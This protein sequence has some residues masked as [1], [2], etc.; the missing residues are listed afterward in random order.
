[1]IKRSTLVVFLVF[2]F[3]LA[4]C[5]SPSA[6]DAIPAA[7]PSQSMPLP[8]D[9]RDYRYCEVIPV[10]QD[11]LTL[12]VTVYNTL[13]LNDC[14]AD[15]WAK[16]DAD[17]ISEQYGASLVKLNGPRYWVLNKIIGK[18]ES[19]NGKVVNF[20]G[21]E[22]LQRATLQ[23]NLWQG[24]IG[25]KFYT[26]NTVKRET[27]FEYWAGNEVYELVSPAG[28]TYIMQSYAQM[29]DPNLTIADLASLGMRLKLPQG[30][31]FQAI[32]LDEDLRL[33]ANGAAYVINDDLYNS[34][35]K[36]LP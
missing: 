1:M 6:T 13:S 4:A 31:T 11:G 3:L 27:I 15:L 24:S 25:D 17:A 5:G 33:E 16:L 14:P 18:G 22:M 35:Q 8:A 34:Y 21:I 23:T 12:N 32:I 10:F 29:A 26:E 30:W 9:L 36:I 28:D 7:T 20:G 19:I 2:T